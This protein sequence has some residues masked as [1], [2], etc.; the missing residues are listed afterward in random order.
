MPAYPD[1][2]SAFANGLVEGTL[3]PGVTAREP[4]EAAHR[5]DVYRNNAAFAEADHDPQPILLR[6]MQASAITLPKENP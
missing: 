3:P 1:L 5:Y 4:Q 6:L 2:V